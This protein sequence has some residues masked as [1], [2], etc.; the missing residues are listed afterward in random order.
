MKKKKCVYKWCKVGPRKFDRSFEE[1]AFTLKE[2]TR[3]TLNYS[4]MMKWQKKNLVEQ[5]NIYSVQVSGKS[6]NKNVK[7][8]CKQLVGLQ[9]LMSLIRLPS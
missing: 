9:M 8:I 1:N 5:S 3:E 6:I 4:G 2:T 7:E